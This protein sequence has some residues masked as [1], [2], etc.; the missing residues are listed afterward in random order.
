MKHDMPPVTAFDKRIKR[1][2]IG[3]DHQFFVITAPGLEQLCLE[4]LM[5]LQ[6]SCSNV[7]RVNGGVTFTGR[8]NDCYLVNLHL[9]LAS[10]ILMRIDHCKVSNFLKLQ[11]KIAAI[12][13][14][15]YLFKG[16]PLR[17]HVSSHH[18]RLYHRDAIGE[19]VHKTIV[20]RLDECGVTA[21]SDTS[22]KEYQ[23]IFV[24]IIDDV[25][26]VSI[27][28]SGELLHK[29]G[30]KSHHAAAPL[31]E[32][33]A[34]AILRC[35]G[36]SGTKPL[37][38]PMCGSG[39]FSLEAAM[40]IKK[41]PAG[42]F[43]EFAFMQWPGFRPR[44]WI[45]VRSQCK[46]FF[47]NTAQPQ[48]F[49]ADTDERICKTL[50]QCVEH[51]HFSDVVQVRCQDFFHLNPQDF[52]KQKGLV[53]LNPPYG[54]RMGSRKTAEE[55]FMAIGRKLRDVYT[56]W[57]VAILAPDMHML[58]HVPCNNLQQYHLYHGGLKIYLFVGMI[59]SNS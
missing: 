32:T 57:N 51:Y 40:M 58:K 25:C 12:P 35:A 33:V 29:R 52:T 5:Q 36:F 53:V 8:L 27:D 37:I 10:R 43:R 46:P 39:T 16:C 9:R 20:Q 19:R 24:R 17:L 1:H 55:L 42:W 49:A 21:P 3:R 11:K 56:G 38:D 6:H 26:T 34:A 44:R 4:E 30:I 45:Y 2:I 41:I 31:R 23:Q 48:V 13:W 54:L 50:R 14:E 18:S 28:S 59:H 22:I 47:V 15:L 7:L